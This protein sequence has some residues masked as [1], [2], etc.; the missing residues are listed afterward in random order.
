MFETIIYNHLSFYFKSKL[1]PNQ[2]GFPKSKYMVT[3]L[4]TYLND[5]TPS[6]C[7]QGQSD[8]VYFDLSQAFDNVPHAL[9]LD[10]LS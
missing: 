4:V 6:V 3:N 10:K 9:L 7:S 2:H 8:S 1:N 5:I